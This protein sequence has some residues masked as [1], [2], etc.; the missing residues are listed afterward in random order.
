MATR[1]E[2]ALEKQK[3]DREKEEA[4]A[5]KKKADEKKKVSEGK[6]GDKD[7]AVTKR[8]RLHIG[9]RSGDHKV[10]MYK[11]TPRVIFG[12]CSSDDPGGRA[13]MYVLMGR[14]AQNVWGGSA[15]TTLKQLKDP[16]TGEKA[17]ALQLTKATFDPIGLYEKINRS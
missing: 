15:V 9:A 14:V 6:G 2:K 3:K 10:F 4:D 12:E 11:V 8:D 1:E 17:Y 7:K 5:K 13:S 16:A